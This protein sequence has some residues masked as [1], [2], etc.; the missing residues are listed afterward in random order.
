MLRTAVLAD[1]WNLLKAAHRLDQ[2]V[3]LSQLPRVIAGCQADRHIVFQRFYVGP[4][5]GRNA[6]QEV[7]RLAQEARMAGFEWVVCATEGAYAKTTVDLAITADL[8][9]WAYCHSA[10]VIALL[11]GD[12]GYAEAVHRAKAVGLRVEVYAIRSSHHLSTALERSANAVYDLEALGVLQP[13]NGDTAAVLDEGY[14][15]KSQ[16]HDAASPLQEK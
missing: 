4:S 8:L 6:Q 15:N 3:N 2:H 1:G 13:S 16:R 9:T 12:G 5:S 7:D 11:S 14:M 10:D